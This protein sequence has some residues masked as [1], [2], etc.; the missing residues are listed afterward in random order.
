VGLLAHE[1]GHLFE[2]ETNEAKTECFAVQRIAELARILGVSGSY[3]DGLAEVYWKD[4]YPRNPPGYRTSL[5]RDGGPLDLNP[6]SDK[7]P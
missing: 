5:C 1:S 3:A 6:R 2:S 4:L 7:W